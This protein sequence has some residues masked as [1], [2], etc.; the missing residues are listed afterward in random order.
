MN[1]GKSGATPV[2]AQQPNAGVGT[3]S[4][5]PPA[6]TTDPFY[7][8]PEWRALVAE[9]IRERGASRPVYPNCDC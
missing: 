9:I 5:K 7:R 8:W 4:A 3:R 1:G 6:K 2:D